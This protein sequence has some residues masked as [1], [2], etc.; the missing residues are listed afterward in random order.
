MGNARFIAALTAERSVKIK[1]LATNVEG[2]LA[3]KLRWVQG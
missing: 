1:G 2:L 3:C